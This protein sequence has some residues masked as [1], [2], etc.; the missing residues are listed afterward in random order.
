MLLRLHT[1][2]VEGYTEGQGPI[3]YLTSKVERVIDAGCS[4]VFSDGQGLATFTSWYDDLARLDDRIDWEAAYAIWWN[5]T[6]QDMDR[7]RRK[8][9][10]FLIHR[11][12]AWDLIDEIAV[13]SGA[14][15]ASVQATL[16]GHDPAMNRPIVVR[17]DWYYGGGC[18]D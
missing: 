2:R 6:P 15:A 8:Q 14:T 12:V 5:D 11:F 7:Q 1:G 13:V 17:R 16:N 18:H 4:F 10:E 9:A 3:I